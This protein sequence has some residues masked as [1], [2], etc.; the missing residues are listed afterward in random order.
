MKE[1]VIL[2]F[3]SILVS[4]LCA[5]VS[6]REVKG[7]HRN[8]SE[9]LLKIRKDNPQFQSEVYELLD[10]VG[11]LSRVSHSIIQKKKKIKRSSIE[12]R[13]MRLALKMENEKLKS[14]LVSLKK[15]VKNESLRVAEN[16]Q[17]LDILM[18]E[19]SSLLQKT[20]EF[21]A[22]EQEY[23]AKMREVEM[24]SQKNDSEERSEHL[25]ANKSKESS[26]KFGKNLEQEKMP[27]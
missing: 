9:G 27:T 24:S 18:R 11:K 5:G 12:E 3:T 10:K 26:A 22:K 21:M 1:S 8:I 6:T 25:S 17:R 14:N 2:V 19:R 15:D 23:K 13:E 4:N 16:Q 7:L 20:Q